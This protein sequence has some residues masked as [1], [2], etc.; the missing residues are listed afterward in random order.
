MTMDCALD[1]T[2]KA[3]I[4]AVLG[5][6]TFKIVDHTRITHGL[7]NLTLR[8]DADDGQHY[9]LQRVNPIF[10]EEVNRNIEIVSGHL[11]SNKLLTPSV[12]P[13]ADGALDVIFESERW[14]VLSYIEGR[15]MD[16]TINPA[17]IEAAGAL[18]GRFHTALSTLTL[19][20]EQTRP[21]VHDLPR[22]IGQLR[23]SLD[24]HRKHAAHKATS[25]LSDEVFTLA[26]AVPASERLSQS[27]VHG[28]P[29]ISNV[30]FAADEDRA[31]CLVDLDTLCRMPI[32]YELGDALRSWCN[33]RPEDSP[34]SDFKVTLMAAALRGYLAQ[35]RQLL[36]EDDFSAVIPAVLQIH[37]ELA[38]RF[39]AD[40][41]EERYFG[42]DSSRY[43]RASEHNLARA[44][45]QLQ[46]ARSLARQ[47]GRAE[48]LIGALCS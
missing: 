28:D 18:L 8:L 34:E 35:A 37:Y 39:L 17:L 3:A 45:A 13:T 16:A 29:K 2:T 33:P 15:T 25:E 31:L 20:L 21:P 23:R 19:E 7:I 44:R 1:E 43:P 26:Q 6:Y 5:H 10:G 11:A 38:A 12:I 24:D 41:L 36:T 22:H 42:W 32:V 30:I 14:R 47:R 40:A 9:I 48:H 4:N 46:A 27:V